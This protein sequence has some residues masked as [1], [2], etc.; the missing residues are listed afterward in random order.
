MITLSICIVSYRVKDLLRECLRSIYEN[1]T[2]LSFEI[3]VI[4]NNSDDD[5]VEMV[6]AEFPQVV[7]VENHKNPGFAAAC[8]QAIRLSQGKFVL[9]LNPDTVVLPGTLQKVIDFMETK[10][11]AGIVGCRLLNPDRTLQLSCKSFPSLIDSFSLNS[12]LYKLFPHTWLFGKCYMSYFRHDKLKKVNVVMGAFLLIRRRTIEE[13]GLMDGDLCM[14]Y[15]ET[16]LCLRAVR[17]GWKV[18]FFPEAE[19]IHYGG[20]SVNSMPNEMLVELYKS[21]RKFFE[22]HHSWFAGQIAKMLSFGGILLR[23]FLW[24]ALLLVQKQNEDIK[25]KKERYLYALKWH[26]GLI[27]QDSNLSNIRQR[28][29]VQKGSSCQV[30]ENRA[31]LDRKLPESDEVSTEDRVY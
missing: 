31:L 4:D 18:Y 25:E 11:D 1:A 5:S 27:K 7:L 9:L 3:I 22:K 17:A 24:S 28:E 19:I 15:E 8:N 21:Q 6:Q 13:I 16:D 30:L 2:S 26:V 12:C 10:R 20:Q 29:G 23:A 14:Y